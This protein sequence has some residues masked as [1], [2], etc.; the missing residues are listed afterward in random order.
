MFHTQDPDTCRQ[1]G[2]IQSDQLSALAGGYQLLVYNGG[3][4]RYGTDIY[5]ELFPCI[6]IYLHLYIRALADTAL[7]APVVQA[8]RGVHHQLA[9]PGVTLYKP[10]DVL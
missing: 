10:L 6:S 2:Q 4:T 7:A 1:V 9:V 3:I 5:G 8:P